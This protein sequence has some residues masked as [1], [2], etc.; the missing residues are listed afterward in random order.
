[1]SF[2]AAIGSFWHIDPYPALSYYQVR[3]CMMRKYYQLK[4]NVTYCRRWIFNPELRGNRSPVDFR[5]FLI[6]NDTI[7][8]RLGIMTKF[9]HWYVPNIP[10]HIKPPAYSSVYF[11][12]VKKSCCSKMLF[13]QFLYKYIRPFIL[14]LIF[15]TIWPPIECKYPSAAI[16]MLYEIIYA[17]S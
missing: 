17:F 11:G 15:H 7:Y 2:E 12:Y 9:P 8:Y 6:W 5:L 1:M 13:N 14:L 4:L 3:P 10:P 16:E